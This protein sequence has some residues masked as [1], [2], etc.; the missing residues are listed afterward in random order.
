MQS[1]ASVKHK[2]KSKPPTSV[3][4]FFRGALNL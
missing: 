4:W 1:E 2:Q 3:K